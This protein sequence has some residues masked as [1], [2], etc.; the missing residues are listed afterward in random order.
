MEF[1]RPGSAWRHG[2]WCGQPPGFTAR[3]IAGIPTFTDA[4]L[5]PEEG[6]EYDLRYPGR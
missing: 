4:V 3:A 1:L 5:V 6:M 2:C